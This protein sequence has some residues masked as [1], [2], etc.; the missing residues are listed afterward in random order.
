M[1]KKVLAVSIVASILFM[2]L[3][4]GLL[5]LG[6]FCVNLFN[7]GYPIPLYVTSGVLAGV[8]FAYITADF[9]HI[10]KD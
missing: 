7:N 4:A 6:C 10:F 9:Y 5:W 8:Y 1:D 3:A 2:S